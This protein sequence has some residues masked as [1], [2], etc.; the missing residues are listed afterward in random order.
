MMQLI[1]S[2]HYGGFLMKAIE[3]IKKFGWVRSQ[4]LVIDSDGC[5]GIRPSCGGYIDRGDLKKYTDAYELVQSYG[6]LDEAKDHT[7]VLA[8]IEEYEQ[9]KQLQKAITLVEEVGEL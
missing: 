2:Q 1:W 8:L 6:G 4:R 9:L 7:M 5:S 3:F